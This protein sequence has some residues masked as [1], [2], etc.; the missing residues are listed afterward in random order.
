MTN[1]EYK[2]FLSKLERY[3]PSFK[4]WLQQ[5]SHDWRTM[6]QD[7]YEGLREENVT[8]AEALEVLTGWNTGR[9]EG[10]PIGFENQRFL[11]NLLTAVR[12]KRAEH[13]AN[14][15]RNKL[16]LEVLGDCEDLPIRCKVPNKGPLVGRMVAEFERLRSMK[17]SKGVA[18][19]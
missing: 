18:T 16:S 6:R 15:N 2:E 1:E 12:Q 13:R 17:L 19:A 14:H 8:L 9:I 3:F 10:A 11:A 4:A 5:P 7:Y